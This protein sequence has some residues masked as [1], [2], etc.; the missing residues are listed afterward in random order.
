MF[1]FPRFPPGS[2]A[3]VTAHHGRRVAPFGDLWITGCQPLP[4]AFR[5]VAAS[6]LGSRRQGIHR[7]PFSAPVPLSDYSA[8]PVF[9]SVPHAGHSVTHFVSARQGPACVR[10]VLARYGFVTVRFSAPNQRQ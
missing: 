5:R 4:R 9:A 6:F 10:S 2:M 7:P 1:Q 3:R 8:K